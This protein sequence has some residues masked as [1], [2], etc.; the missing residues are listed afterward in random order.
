MKN[1][2]A[3]EMV[4][5]EPLVMEELLKG[6]ED[7]PICSDKI[8]YNVNQKLTGYD[9]KYTAVKL[10]NFVNT[11]RQEAYPILSDSRGYYI[12]YDD[13]YVYQQIKSLEIRS[14]KM[15]K[16]ALGLRRL[17]KKPTPQPIKKLKADDIDFI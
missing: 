15:L 9:Y 1:V 6:R 3:F 16:A 11:L 2:R 8:I 7:E 5:V 4:Y 10:R 17:L 13:E 12:S 14:E